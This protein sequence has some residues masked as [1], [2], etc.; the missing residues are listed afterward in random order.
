MFTTLCKEI[1]ILSL[2]QILYCRKS[3]SFMYIMYMY[4]LQIQVYKYFSDFA[5][6]ISGTDI[7]PDSKVEVVGMEI[8]PQTPGT[9]LLYNTL[10]SLYWN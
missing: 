2:W 9:V 4:M 6:S 5:K 7:W 1:L 10:F 3:L 8:H